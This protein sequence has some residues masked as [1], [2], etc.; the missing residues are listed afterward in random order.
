MEKNNLTEPGE[1]KLVSEIETDY[2]EY[3]DSVLKYIKSPKS[4]VCDALP[5]K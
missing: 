1:D 5:S 3:R 4:D 2:N